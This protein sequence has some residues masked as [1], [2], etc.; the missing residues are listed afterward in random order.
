MKVNGYEIGRKPTDEEFRRY[1]FVN[2]F[3]KREW[4]A[5]WLG[6]G[7]LS[8][9]EFELLVDRF[10]DLDFS[11]EE[12]DALGYE[13]ERL[14]DER[15]GTPYDDPADERWR[16]EFGLCDDEEAELTRKFVG[17]GAS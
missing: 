3:C 6:E 16:W 11:A 1:F 9:D 17:G 7:E 12:D 10:E 8:Q 15:G 4:I 5:G 13:L 14:L 2:R